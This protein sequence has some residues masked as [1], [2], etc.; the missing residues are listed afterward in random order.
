MKCF[1]GHEE[2]KS[3]EKTFFMDSSKGIAGFYKDFVVVPCTG[4]SCFVNEQVE[5][6]NC[7]DMTELGEEW[8]V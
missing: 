7:C 1:S 6:K 8:S 5:T 2:R 4:I 3:R